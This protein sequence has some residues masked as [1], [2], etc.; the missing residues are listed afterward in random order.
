MN[1]DKIN[2]LFPKLDEGESVLD[3]VRK[4]WDLDAIVPTPKWDVECPV[5]DNNDTL[6]KMWT[7]FK[8]KS[9]VEESRHIY[10]CDVVF[11]CQI[12]SFNFTFGVP[13][14]EKMFESHNHRGRYRW[15]EV[16][17]ML[18][19]EGNGMSES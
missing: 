1:K 11:K 13:I 12:C 3:R 15:R 10:R 7:F 19:G 5:C 4:R 2:M 8:K 16:K 6:A 14:P 18:E 17:E 9:G